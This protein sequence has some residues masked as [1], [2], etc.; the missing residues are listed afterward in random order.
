MKNSLVHS[1]LGENECKFMKLD[2][3]SVRH[4]VS[5]IF[6]IT[7]TDLIIIC[8]KLDDIRIMKWTTIW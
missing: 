6:H 3:N 1:V 8:A 7:K 4:L 5:L 2:E